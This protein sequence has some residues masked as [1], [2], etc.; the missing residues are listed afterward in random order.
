MTI[1][2]GSPDPE[3]RPETRGFDRPH[4]RS[5]FFPLLLLSAGVLLLLSNMNIIGPEVWSNIIRLWPLIIIVGALDGIYRGEGLA[6]QIFWLG[7]GV[8]FL[9]A[10]LGYLSVN[11]WDLLL[12]F[13]PVFLIALGIDI[14]LGNR[15][16]PWARALAVII[17]LALLAGVIWFAGTN[18]VAPGG[19]LQNSTINQPLDDATSA[20]Y[21]LAMAAGLFEISRGAPAGQLVS[22]EVRSVGNSGVRES[23]TNENGRVIYML[24]DDS[25]TVNIGSGNNNRYWTLQLSEEIPASLDV[26]LAAGQM[27]LQLAGLDLNELDATL[28]TGQMQVELPQQGEYSVDLTTVIG[29]TVIRIPADT[30]AEIQVD[31]I[32]PINLNGDGLTQNGR[33]ITAAGSGPVVKIKVLNII[34]ATTIERVR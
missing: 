28:A 26:T 18:F 1:S 23:I 2:N 27:R 5:I 4:R 16:E 24:R 29:E 21:D 10:S 7:L 31:G 34:G 9:L 11:I 19:G 13:W 6:G 20:H 30:A 14:L 22:G 17:S 15:R 12:R 3:P 25:V 8:L 32:F 33:T